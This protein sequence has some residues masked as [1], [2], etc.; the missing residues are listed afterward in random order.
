MG[1]F[2][3]QFKTLLKKNRLIRGKSCCAMVC[4]IIFP[5]IIVLIIFAILVLIQAFKPNYDPYN[6]N[7]FSYS[8][9]NNSKFIYGNQEGQLSAEQQGV[10]T[11]MK[12]RVSIVKKITMNEVNYFFLELNNK[13]EMETYF[14]NNSKHTFGAVWFN[15]SQVASVASPFKYNIRLD[16][17][18]VMDN[19][20]IIDKNLDSEIY[21]KKSFSNIQVAMDQAIFDYF[22]LNI[23]L[24]VTGQRFPDPWTELWMKWIN[25][26]DGLF[27]NAGSTFV[28][29]A[30]LIFV[31]RLTTDL[32]VEKETKIREGM[33][34]MGLND[35]A[36][37]L[38]WFVMQLFTALPVDFV[39]IIILKGSQVIHTTS[40]GIVIVLLVLYLI[41][42]LL[43]AFIFSN[44]FDKS[45]FSGLLTFVII[46]VVNICGIFVGNTEFNT[47][48]KLFLCLLSPVAI[49]CSFYAMSVRDLTDVL[50]VDWDYIIT[51]KQVIGMLVLDI[52]VYLFLVWYLDKVI[53]TEYGTKEKWYFLFTKSY[54]KNSSNSGRDIFDIESTYQNDDVEMIPAE[55]RNKNKV[56]VSIR[57]LRKEF[58]TG[59]GLRVAVNDLYLDMFEGQIHAFLGPNGSGKSTTIGMLTGLIEPTRGTASILGNDITTNMGRV[60]RSLG[61]CPQQD[62]IWAQLTVLEHLKIYASLKGVAKKEIKS[63]AVKM[64]NEVGL[65]EKINSPAGSL[66]G[67]QKRKLCL[68]IA[69]I[70]R[71]SVIFLDE[72]T[73]GMDPLSRR[74]VWDFLLKYKKS[75]TIILTTHFM[76]EADFLG[77]RIAI[78]THGKLR[79]DGSSLYLKNKFGCGYLL[80]CSKKLE[81][82]EN[83]NTDNVTEFIHRYIPEANVLSDAGTE[84]SYRFPTSSVPQFSNFFQNF[85]QQ[86]ES[87][88]ITTYGI[89]VTTL[90]EVFLKIGTEV[91]DGFELNKNQVTDE[92][93]LKANI[94]IPSQGITA[95]QQLK[96]LLIKR[97]RTSKKDMKAFFLSLLIPLIVI[98]G[99]IVVYK[100]VNTATLFY[101]NVTTPLELSYDLYKSYRVPVQTFTLDNFNLLDKSPYFSNMTYI[102]ESESLEDY[103]VENYLEAA[104][105]LNFTNSISALNNGNKVSYIALYNFNYIHSLPVQINL[106]NDALLRKHNDFGIQVTSMPFKHVLSNFELASQNMNIQSIV[107]FVIIIMGGFS[108]MA[109]SFA[110]SI[111]Q[112]RANRIKRLLYIS[113]CKKYIYWLSNLIWDY[114][115][116]FILLIITCIILA[117]VKDE[118]KDQFG[119]FILSLI[120]FVLSVIP[121]SYLLSYRFKSYGSTVGAVAAIHFAI[122]IVFTIVSL[123]L[124]IQVIIEKSQGLQDASDIVDIVFDIFSP[125]YAFSRVLL[126]ISGFPGSIRLGYYEIDNYWSLKYGGI[127]IIIL[128]IHCIVWIPWILLLDY[129]P[130]FKGYFRN[131]KNVAAPPPPS[132]E[133]SDVSL[134]RERLLQPASRNEVIQLRNLHKLFPGKGKNPDKNA[135]YNSTLGIP[136]GQTFGLLGMNGAGKTTTLSMLCGDVV[137]TSGEITING[138]DLITNRSQALKSISMVP[139]FDALISLLSAR[140]QITLYCRIKGIPEDKISLVV[141]SFVQMMDMKR[142]ANSNCGGYSGGNK[143]KLSL[144]I[145]MLGNPSV[146]FLDEPST[147]CDAVVRRYLWNVVSELGKDRS[148]IITTHSMEE[149]QALCGRVTI[150]KDG[151]FTCL[152]SIQHVKNKFGT[153]YSIDVKFK[154]EYLDGG[155]QQVLKCFSTA[156]LLDEHDLIASFEL[157]NDPNNPVK[158]SEIFGTLQQDLSS[159]LDDYSVSQTSLEQVF[160][161]LTGSGYAERLQL[162]NNSQIRGD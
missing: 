130:E 142:I 127:H 104:G 109:G 87:F 152:G 23:T 97:I 148:I 2:N 149:C 150:M 114:L 95:R 77:D 14:A 5:I 98:I 72:P 9:N 84:L 47:G 112:E 49:A 126:I 107:Y 22:G 27:K 58:Q 154:K 143:R 82:V 147:G 67:G 81:S 110:G 36:Y 160:L 80:T 136:R 52:F 122:G 74:G 62:I 108:L 35:F 69:F 129:T 28:T 73:S 78:I 158:I 135:V 128:A 83:F 139:Q 131:P 71:S 141:E 138:F 159:M 146:V 65:G 91:S 151:K 157:P 120:F 116:G 105:S 99:S 24:D 39:I 75:K 79:C 88:Q 29:A 94:A 125:L 20:L 123:N 124:R 21:A 11:A 100:E 92:D 25:G 106:A 16:S 101:N 19:S 46:L 1:E 70:G 113:G 51:E 32:L 41:S 42:L 12:T 76:D 7:A 111:A 115:F 50:T 6:A 162:F 61:C 31:F 8:V 4:E 68:G 132:D 48:V 54:W 96:G 40:W 17:D 133:D 37:F 15:D 134:E 57:N 10:I 34:M 153:G 56:T 44:F 55:V 66:S 26:R 85:D 119:L 103:L 102:Q 30:L 121:L 86:L 117:V 118:Y 156:S 93:T 13:E 60:R 45:K 18:Y 145:A 161:K 33:K 144:S 63:E 64:A 140:E 3:N 137:P 38:S 59:D 89:S 155:V 43:L 53:P 90:E